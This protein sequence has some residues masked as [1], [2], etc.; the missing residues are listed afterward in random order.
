MSIGFHR[1]TG[2]CRLCHGA[3]LVAPLDVGP[4]SVAPLGACEPCH[5][6]FAASMPAF[7]PLPAY[8]MDLDLEL[9]WVGVTDADV[10]EALQ[11]VVLRAGAAVTPDLQRAASESLSTTDLEDLVMRLRRAAAMPPPVVPAERARFLQRLLPR[12]K[13]SHA[14]TDSL[15]RDAAAC[16][17]AAGLAAS[18]LQGD[19]SLTE[20]EVDRLSVRAARWEELQV[21]Q[22]ICFLR[23][24][25]AAL[26]VD[27]KP[28]SDLGAKLLAAADRGFMLLGALPHFEQARR[29]LVASI[30][31]AQHRDDD[32]LA[33]ISE[34]LPAADSDV[35]DGRLLLLR[36][37]AMFRKGNVR[38]ADKALE[39]CRSWVATRTGDDKWNALAATVHYNQFVRA[40]AVRGW[41][42][43]RDAIRVYCQLRP[44]DASARFALA[45]VHL[46]CAST[47]AA[48]DELSSVLDDPASAEIRWSYEHESDHEEGVLLYA[49]CLYHHGRF[50]EAIRVA[51]RF[52]VGHPTTTAAARLS[53][54]VA[55][56]CHRL[57]R[58]QQALEQILK[59]AA[60]A[61]SPS[62]ARDDVWPIFASFL[63]DRFERDDLPDLEPIL[64][65]AIAAASSIRHRL[66]E[67][68]TL[69]L[70]WFVRQQL[71]R[72]LGR[73]GVHAVLDPLISPEI[74]LLTCYESL[75]TQNFARAWLHR[76]STPLRVL[77][78]V[79]RA[80]ER[81]PL[82]TASKFAAV[83]QQT[84]IR[85]VRAVPRVSEPQQFE[86]D[87]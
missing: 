44:D 37:L 54:V 56:C 40:A 7:D 46:H 59:A 75:A 19:H 1:Q 11:A 36:A 5:E 66:G 64:G 47:E 16:D 68:H 45:R 4:L 49:T 50:A 85:L 15:A 29:A 21:L 42:A 70:L 58:H 80:I 26:S 87:D 65:G 22:C 3:G 60:A 69:V 25:G 82:A 83:V 35:T 12:K 57:G 63:V 86:D 9:R 71:F 43:A 81:M 53:R 6:I 74:S 30:R 13:A 62:S 24:A 84:F 17:L 79:S 61:T 52:R 33:E 28:L 14:P 32:A 67:V 18:A 76:G 48:R 8:A 77:V 23:L 73:G 72:R 10:R 51:D 38:A 31:L 20:R 78:A 41:P 55:R 2:T 34:V 27:K 39:R